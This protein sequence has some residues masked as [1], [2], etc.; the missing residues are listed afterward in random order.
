MKRIC[1]IGV[2]VLGIFQMASSQVVGSKF[3]PFS[4][5]EME[6]VVM[7]VQRKYEMNERKVDALID[8]L[9]EIKGQTSDREFLS[10]MDNYTKI[11]KSFYDLDLARMDTEIREIQFDIKNEVDNYNR[12]QNE[13]VN[14]PSNTYDKYQGLSG[15]HSVTDLSPLM[16]AP[17]VS[18]EQIGRIKS[19]KVEIIR[20]VNDNYFYVRTTIENKVVEGYL[21]A[22]WIK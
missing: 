8:Y 20:Q 19:G 3:K 5:R 6:N 22:V 11:L 4:Y 15:I 16:E 7:T 12:K 21:S 18:A 9:F 10:R 17:N 13:S 2:C 1:I 14:K